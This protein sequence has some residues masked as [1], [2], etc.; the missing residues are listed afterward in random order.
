MWPW[1]RGYSCITLP[2]GFERPDVQDLR[3]HVE[4]GRFVFAFFLLL[5]LILARRLLLRA[6]VLVVDCSDLVGTLDLVFQL[7]V[8]NGDVL[9]QDLLPA[10]LPGFVGRL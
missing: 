5:G 3:R 1:R 10:D 7:V 4:V 8:A 2:V 9:R 6:L